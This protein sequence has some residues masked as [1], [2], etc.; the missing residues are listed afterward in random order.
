MCC[1]LAEVFNAEVL[2]RADCTADDLIDVI[3][4]NRVYLKALYVR[5][6]S[7]LRSS[8]VLVSLI[9]LLVSLTVCGLFIVLEIGLQQDRHTDP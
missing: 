5:S 6:F 4:G 3:E 7:S 2:F 1:T 9:V 8:V